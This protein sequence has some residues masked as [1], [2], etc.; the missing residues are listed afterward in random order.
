MK[1]LNSAGVRIMRL[2]E[3]VSLN[4]QSFTFL[5]YIHPITLPKRHNAAYR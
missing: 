5:V 2:Q 1:E 3:G 4:S